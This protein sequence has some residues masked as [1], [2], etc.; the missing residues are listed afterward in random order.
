M[1]VSIDKKSGNVIEGHCDC[2]AGRSGYCNHVMALL[3]ELANYSLRQLKSVPEEPVCTSKKREWGL[4]SDKKKYPLPVM[5]T[6][7]Y[8]DVNKKGVSCIFI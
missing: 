6:S 1:R 4:P 5:S 3:F 7:I 8:G 2:P